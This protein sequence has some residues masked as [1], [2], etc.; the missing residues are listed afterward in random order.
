GGGNTCGTNYKNRGGGGMVVSADGSAAN[1][2]VVFGPYMASAKS[3]AHHPIGANVVTTPPTDQ[4]RAKKTRSGICL[5]THAARARWTRF[6]AWGG[7]ACECVCVFGG[8]RTSTYLHALH[9]PSA[10]T[11]P[12]SCRGLATTHTNR[13]GSLPCL[14]KTQESQPQSTHRTA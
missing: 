14:Q 4:G 5:S 2:I 12:S 13:P 7:G 6:R 8:D 3:N 10:C 9:P 1:A 11:T